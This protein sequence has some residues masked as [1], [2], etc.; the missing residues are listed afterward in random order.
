MDFGSPFYRENI[1]KKRSKPLTNRRKV[2]EKLDHAIRTQ[3]EEKPKKRMSQKQRRL[4]NGKGTSM[5]ATALQKNEKNCN[6]CFG[7]RCTFDGNSVYSN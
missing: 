5:Q 1:L 2:G 4:G 7:N 6:H 3:K